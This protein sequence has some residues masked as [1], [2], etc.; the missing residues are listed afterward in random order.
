MGEPKEI[1]ENGLN[2]LMEHEGLVLYA[3][4][5]ADGSWPR[6]RIMPGDRVRGKL[7]IGYGHTGGDVV[8]GMEITEDEAAELLAHDLQ[9]PELTVSRRVNVPLNQSQF[10]ALTLFVFNVGTHAFVNSSLLRVLNEGDYGEAA[11]KLLDW[12]WTTINGVKVES[13]GLVKRRKAER[14]LFLS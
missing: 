9:Y 5:D 4:D 1:S 7:T 2:V 14:E 12:R 3:Y 6:K 10:D 8:P 13:A 11:D